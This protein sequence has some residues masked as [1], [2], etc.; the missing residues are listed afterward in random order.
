MVK[1]QQSAIYKIKNLI[2]NKFYIGSTN[3]PER[4]K[5]EH[6][7]RLKQNSHDNTYLQNAYNKYGKKNLKFEIIE[8]CD[9]QEQYILEQKWI[10]KYKNKNILYNISLIANE[11]PHTL[12]SIKKMKNKIKGRKPWN[13]GKKNVYTQETKNKISN[14]LKGRYIGG[15]N[16]YSKMIV[17]LVD[18]KIYNSFSECSKD[19]NISR[20][21]LHN[22][23]TN[24]II[25]TP[26]MYMLYDEYI[27][28]S[29]QEI[30]KIKNNILKYKRSPVNSKKVIRLD[31][32][33][34]YNSINECAR[35]NNVSS[36]IV[37]QHCYGLRKNIKFAFSEH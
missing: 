17:R 5:K 26:Q 8:Y 23:T 29:K 15:K 24:K 13:K 34:I 7:L 25:C 11:P 2:N 28:L 30:K 19:N 20:S 27:K 36:Y 10:D 22:H 21:T 6:F 9:P 1:K 3:N 33:K 18:G 35:D 37:S 14:T 4:R 31:D 16:P 32:N 12:E